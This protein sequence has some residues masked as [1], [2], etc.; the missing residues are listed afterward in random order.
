MGI[1]SDESAESV[2]SV[3]T[4]TLREFRRSDRKNLED[5]LYDLW[6]DN[7]L[8]NNTKIT[9]GED[10]SGLSKVKEHIARDYLLIFLKHSS[11]SVTAMDSSGI[12]CGYL[13]G[14]CNPRSQRSL[15]S[16]YHDA[17]RSLAASLRQYLDGIILKTNKYG[18]I[19]LEHRRDTQLALSTL[20]RSVPADCE[21][22]L[23]LFAVSGNLRGKGIGSQLI[24][25][26]QDYL[27]RNGCGRYYLC[28]DDYCNT[29]YYEKHGYMRAASTDVDYKDGRKGMKF[30]LYVRDL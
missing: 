5:L 21:G 19:Y 30:H 24:A 10:F 27:R 4:V 14:R 11:Y 20:E 7:I 29:G 1:V 17:I 8:K 22:E 3:E 12:P 13:L 9:H 28:A 26:F 15:K 23:I 16:G 18:R 25:Y 6:L 2:N